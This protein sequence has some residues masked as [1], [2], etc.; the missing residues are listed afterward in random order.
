LHPLIPRETPRWKGFYRRRACVER[1]F[2]RLKNA[3][4]LT[5]L[6]VRR[7]ERVRLHADLIDP[8]PADLSAAS[9]ERRV[10]LKRVMA[11]ASR[12]RNPHQPLLL[13]LRFHG[14][15]QLREAHVQC[16]GYPPDGAPRWV[17]ASAF[18]ASDGGD[19]QPSSVRHL[20]LR[21]ASP[22]A[23]MPQGASERLVGFT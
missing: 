21:D 14:H 5:P 15:R 20:F 9:G 23:Q 19:G 17:R 7:M 1:A 16:V 3:W 13:P 10:G 22:F 8:R 12:P 18:H 4:G 6:R 11:D 2:G